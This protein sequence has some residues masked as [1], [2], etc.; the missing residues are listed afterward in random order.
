V[1]YLGAAILPPIL[2]ELYDFGKLVNRY[3][4]CFCTRSC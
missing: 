4:M 3:E 1:D 2:A